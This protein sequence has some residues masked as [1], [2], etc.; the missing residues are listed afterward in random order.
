MFRAMSDQDTPGDEPPSRS[1]GA[2]HPHPPIVDVVDATARV[3]DA[4]RTALRGRL[5]AALSELAATGEARVRIVG[6][7]EMTDLHA[8]HKGD[9]TTTDVLTFD[10]S[11][12]D[13]DA[14]PLDVDL[15]VCLDEAER[16][17]ADRGHGVGEELLLY[18]V[19]GVLHC[20]GFDDAT[21]AAAERMHAEEDRLL[22]AIGVGPVFARPTLSDGAA[23]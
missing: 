16:Q 12:R 18:A 8:R 3:D 20:L 11:E 19:H 21:D 4:A 22:A 15:I 5:A 23:P 14:R 13:G 1:P 9:A 10:L 2:P 6:D 17:A 7:R